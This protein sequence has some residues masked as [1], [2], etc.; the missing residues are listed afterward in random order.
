[1]DSHAY[2]DDIRAMVLQ[3]KE[4]EAIYASL[5]QSD[6]QRAADEFRPLYDAGHGKACKPRWAKPATALGQHRYQE[7]GLQ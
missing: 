3:G 1:V 2:D 7:F 5:S 4:A 6:V